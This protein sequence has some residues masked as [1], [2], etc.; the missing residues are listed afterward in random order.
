MRWLL[1]PNAFL[2]TNNVDASISSSGSSSESRFCTGIAFA[3]VNHKSL[4]VPYVKDLLNSLKRRFLAHC[5]CIDDCK[6]FDKILDK[7]VMAVEMEGKKERSRLPLTHS[8]YI[9]HQENEKPQRNTGIEESHQL[10]NGGHSQLE[11]DL[12]DI[13][14]SA[15]RLNL[16]A[17]VATDKTKAGRRAVGSNNRSLTPEQSTT[18]KKGTVWYDGS[19]ER[20]ITKKDMESLDK[21]KARGGVAV[22]H[23]VF[24]I[25]LYEY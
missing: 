15:N 11:K 10:E 8:L 22:G 6:S 23:L 24:C 3:T 16:G 19:S 2:T 12:S 13:E 7:I 18:T 4:C 17:W 9:S 1:E 25:H 14:V 21:S 20:K 5:S